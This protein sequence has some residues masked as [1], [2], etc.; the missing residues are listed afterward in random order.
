[1]TYIIA[2]IAAALVW[3]LRLLWVEA[4]ARLLSCRVRLRALQRKRKDLLA[5]S[6]SKT[7]RSPT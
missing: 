5:K 3:L 4:E 7:E 2:A 1:M 6:R